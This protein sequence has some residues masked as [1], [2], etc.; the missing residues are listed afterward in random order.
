MP[1]QRPISIFYHFIIYLKVAFVNLAVKPRADMHAWVCAA[2]QKRR[3]LRSA[4]TCLVAEGLRLL[5]STDGAGAG[6]SAALYALIG[7]DLKL[8][9]TLADSANGALGST[10]AAHNASI[11][12]T[13][14]HF[15]Y[16]HL[17]VVALL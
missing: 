10:C 15:I 2:E 9:V 5:G 16:L 1:Q 4:K 7:I 3:A 17:M 11:G 6:T 8:A 14:C 12:N 13:E